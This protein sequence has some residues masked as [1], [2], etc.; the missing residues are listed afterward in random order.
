MSDS[1]LVTIEEL[2]EYLSVSVP[3]LR[4]WVRRGY[5][6]GSAYI[7]AGPTYRFD[8]AD[9]RAALQGQD[10]NAPVDTDSHNPEQL[11]LD[12]NNPEN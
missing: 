5:I 6:P 1:K 12:F 2:A 9:V 8:K 11:E 7:K 4:S 3:T 10:L